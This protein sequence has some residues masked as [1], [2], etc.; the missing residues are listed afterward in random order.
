MQF[1]GQIAAVTGA[2]LERVDEAAPDRQTA[3]P[4]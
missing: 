2:G 4:A 1:D 3:V